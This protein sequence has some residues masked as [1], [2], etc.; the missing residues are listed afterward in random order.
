[1]NENNFLAEK[2]D[3][4]K[5]MQRKVKRGKN[6]VGI[7]ENKREKKSINIDDER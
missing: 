5:Q 4:T 7:T 6:E 1:L 3:M 2:K